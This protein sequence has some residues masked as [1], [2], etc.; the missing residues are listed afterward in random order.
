M[1]TDK[2]RPVPA[3]ERAVKN[4]LY[5]CHVDMDLGAPGQQGDCVIDYDAPSDALVQIKRLGDDGE[6]SG[7]RHARCRDIARAVLK[8]GGSDAVG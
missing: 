8:I 2:P 5:G 6:H 3:S 1:T 7:D 4:H